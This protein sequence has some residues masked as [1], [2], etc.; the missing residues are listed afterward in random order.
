MRRLRAE[1]EQGVP[2]DRMAIL[3]R[4]PGPYRAL[5]EEALERADIPAW[6][7]RGSVRPDP[8]GRAFLALLACAAERLPARRF[9]EYLSL[10]EVPDPIGPGA[11]PAAR[12]GWMPAEEEVQP[13][14]LTRGGD[15]APETAEPAPPADPDAAP[16]SAGTLR[17]PWRWERL[18]QDAAVIG[19]HERWARRL[20][21]LRAEVEAQRAALAE[22]GEQSQRIERQLADLGAL[23]N[24][25]LPLIAELHDW[26]A[27]ATWSEWLERLTALATRAL[28][29]PDRVLTLLAELAPMGPIG[30]VALNEVRRV[31]SRRLTELTEPPPA[32][33]AGRVFVGPIDA[34]RGL[35]FDVVLIPGLA[36]RIFPQRLGQ[37]P[38]LPDPARSRLQAQG[39]RLDAER[40]RVESERLALRLALGAAEVRAHLSWPRQDSQGGRPRVPSF[41]GLELL[42]AA[43]GRL[44]GFTEL[45]QRAQQASGA[46]LGWPA[47]TSPQAAIDEAEHDLALLDAALRR[48][49]DEA[50]GAMNYL[51]EVNAHL[52]RALRTRWARYNTGK[53]RSADGVAE[54]GPAGMAAL[55]KH[56]PAARPY[57]PTALQH[58][59]ACPYRF[60]LQAILKLEP[61]EEPEAIDELDPLSRGLVLHETQYRLL[62]R[63]RSERR[64]PLF[65]PDPDRRQANVERAWAE[66]DEVLFDVAKGW[67][68]KLAPAIPRVWDDGIQS[69]RAD[70][71]HTL[72]L[73][74][75]QEEW[76][77]D[78]FELS[79]G[80]RF[81]QRLDHDPR[82]TEEPVRLDE[83]LVLRGSIDLVEQGA[84]GRLRATDYKT[85]KVRATKGMSVGGGLV[86]QPALY[87]LALEKLFPT[88]PVAGAR[89]WY[90]TFT[91]NFTEVEVPL[92]AETRSAVRTVVATVSGAL[93]SGFL[94]RAPAEGAC[95]HCDY[96]A[97]CGPGA[98][99]LARRKPARALE[100]LNELRRLS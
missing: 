7:A 13:A 24:F 5:V 49:G 64:L 84:G 65:A 66:L 81:E 2:F 26:P 55:A 48:P 58:Y 91:G 70:L 98:E 77:P 63:L 69:I 90:C 39:L 45:M 35:S 44:P 79:F 62:Q 75:E 100:P 32:H 19:G 96:A 59:A 60:F 23:R 22:K 42:R 20:D 93:E 41:Y 38:L 46:R 80:L 47:P 68:E 54:L 61:R 85:G 86:L 17:A 99:R 33:R 92:D 74:G 15:E 12:E 21:G 31:L 78:G 40:E 50:F 72:A 16:A 4:A 57:S 10:G 8:S 76:S 30:P 25:A 67:E 3:L 6:F 29:H 97:V 71:R 87:A 88:H 51:V 14:V 18:L 53:W 28:R 83:G 1:A 56:L 37:D 9:A 52:A 27:Q 11:P 73:L 36:E 82:S 95:E 34:A 89:L 94:P 43:E